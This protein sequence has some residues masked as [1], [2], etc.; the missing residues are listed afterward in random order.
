M[1]NTLCFV[2]AGYVGLCTAV[3]FAKKQYNAICV[4]ID[5]NKVRQIN[6]CNPPFFE[7]KLDIFLKQAVSR[8]K[9][10]ATTSYRNAVKK[11]DVL[12]LCLPTPTQKNG[13]VNLYF[14]KKSVQSIATALAT[15][16]KYKLIVVK[17][18]VLPGTTE[19]ILIP[20]LERY[21]GKKA[22]VHFGVCV[23]P[24]FLREGSALQDSMKPDRIVIGALDSRSKNKLLEIY[25]I[26]KVPKVIV[27]MRTAEMIKY[28]TNAFLAAKIS[29][30]NELANI[31]ENLN[32]D[33]YE[34]MDAIALDKRICRA[35][36]DAGAGFGGSCLPK[37]LNALIR[38]SCKK[39]YEPK[40]LS[41]VVAVNEYQPLHIVQIAEE[42]CT[43][44]KG[45]KIALLGITFKPDTDDIRGS[46]A[47]PIAKHLLKKGA[48]VVI[49]DIQRTAMQRFKKQILNSNLKTAHT[50]SDAITNADCCIIQTAWSIFKKLKPIDFLKSGCTRILDC[51]RVYN[52]LEFINAG[53]QYRSIGWKYK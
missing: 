21:S 22:G 23:N 51:R 27:D 43:T 26:F 45:K 31:C 40:L 2:G 13:A 9:L 6:S 34:V 14:I 42:M 18:T 5:R 11:S 4:D 15:T 30:A 33:V 53:V 20:I 17:S 28:A 8:K 3:A 25:K 38:N 50:I 19:N 35:F 29:Y 37:D 52:P 49:Y 1:N 48:K 44:L 10:F 47:L 12:F 36:L 41:A 39:G 32:I 16:D 46:R 7:K 24:E